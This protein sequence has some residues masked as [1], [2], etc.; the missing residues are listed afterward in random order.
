M[1]FIAIDQHISVCADIR[2]I[3]NQLGHTVRE[4]SLSGHASVIGRP[5]GDVPMLTGDQW[6]ATLNER[7]FKEFYEM[8]KDVLNK[9]DGFICCYPPI[10]SML[11][12]YFDKPI[13]IQ[14]PIRYEYGADC[15]P[16]LWEEF[17]KYLQDGVDSGKIILCANNKYDQEYAAGFLQRPVRHIPSLCENTGMSYNPVYDQFL[18]YSSF[19]VEDASGRMIKKHDA[20]KA[21][22]AW[23]T[24][25][26]FR[27]CIH[28]P[29]QIS[30]MSTFEQ[31]TANIPLF[32]PT[33]RY[34][35]EMF[36]TGIP[37][38]NQM[39]WQQCIQRGTSRSL[40]PHPFKYDPNNFS[41]FNCVSNWLKLA[42]YYGEDMK[43][44]RHF[45]SIEERDAILALSNE[46]LFEI[47]K[48]MAAH[49]IIRRQN[50]YSKWASVLDEVRK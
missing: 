5:Q 16:A 40:I 1:R 47:S 6:C 46:D 32:F 19:N 7:K 3:F 12:K 25:A 27:G 48:E 29:Y 38:I 18:Y 36:L 20:L 33:R 22:H 13:I 11:Y 43:C 9:Y 41:D 50:V 49:N 35:M 23:Q 4:V 45:D 10:F 24:I 39:S 44:I 15:N 8:H 30:T 34:L 42:D 31:Y 17:N 2:Y 28:Y 21:G 37:V 14:I 26:D